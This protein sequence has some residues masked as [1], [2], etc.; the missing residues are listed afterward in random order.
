MKEIARHDK[1]TGS[2]EVQISI[3]TAKIENL[4]EVILT[5]RIS[6]YFFA[7]LRSIESNPIPTLEIT[8][9]FLNF[10]KNDKL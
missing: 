6:A 4:S 1:D 9:T 10:S 2:S 5:T 8:L 7:E 3:L